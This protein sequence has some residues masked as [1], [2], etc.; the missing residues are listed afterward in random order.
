MNEQSSRSHMV[1]SLRIDGTNA[2][3]GLKARRSGKVL[4]RFRVGLLE[5]LFCQGSG[6]AAGMA[7]PPQ[8]RTPGPSMPPPW[9]HQTHP[10]NRNRF[11]CAPKGGGRAQPDRPRRQRARQGERRHG[12][13]HEGGTGHQQ[14]PVR[15]GCG[16][17]GGGGGVGAGVSGVGGARVSGRCGAGRVAPPHVAKPASDLR[18]SGPAAPRRPRPAPAATASPQVTSYLRSPTRSSTCPSA[19]P[20]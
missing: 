13:A 17:R 3:S 8:T 19:T 20:S 15:A 1:F 2:S 5:P 4:L 6:R 10:P 12:A 16:W 9:Q 14:E 18:G 7:A 11:P